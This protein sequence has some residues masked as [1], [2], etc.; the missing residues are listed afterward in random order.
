[1]EIQ[2]TEDEIAAGGGAVRSSASGWILN[3]PRLRVQKGSV[4]GLRCTMW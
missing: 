2:L 3:D 4:W 1:L